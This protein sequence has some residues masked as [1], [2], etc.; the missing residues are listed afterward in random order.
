MLLF[1]LL[2]HGPVPPLLP[3]L[4]ITVTELNRTLADL[5]TFIPQTHNEKPEHSA[6]YQAGNR[7]SEKYCLLQ[8]TTVSISVLYAIDKYM[9]SISL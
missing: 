6:H 1:A 8:F 2:S 3:K 9:Q 4:K 5:S 7:L